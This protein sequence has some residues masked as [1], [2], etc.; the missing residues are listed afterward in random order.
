MLEGV[1]WQVA[2]FRVQLHAVVEADGVVSDVRYRL[3]MV[4]VVALP[5][6][7]HLHKD[8]EIMG[9]QIMGQDHG[10]RSPISH[11]QDHG[12]RSPISHATTLGH[13]ADDR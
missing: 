11:G 1:E 6:P 8:H 10:V 13:L 5:N 3:G 9:S 4:G 2:Q 12:V 7:L